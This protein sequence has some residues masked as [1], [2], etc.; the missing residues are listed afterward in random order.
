MGIVTNPTRTDPWGALV[1]NNIMRARRLMMMSE[2]RKWAFCSEARTMI[3]NETDPYYSAVGPVS[4]L[5]KNMIDIDIHITFGSDHIVMTPARGSSMELFH[6]SKAAVT[7][8]LE[9]QIRG[10]LLK[11]FSVVENGHAPRRK[12][13]VGIGR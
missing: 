9:V 7:K 12:D 3:I 6:E 2:P 1:F 8:F 5:M 10:A 11:I 4:A 13:M